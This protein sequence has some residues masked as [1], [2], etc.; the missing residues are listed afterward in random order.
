MAAREPSGSS[1]GDGVDVHASRLDDG[2]TTTI[3]SGECASSGELA[4]IDVSDGSNVRLLTY[5]WLST[6][7]RAL[8]IALERAAAASLCCQPVTLVQGSWCAESVAAMLAIWKVNAVYCPVD[9][10]WPVARVQS[11]LADARP[12]VLLCCRHVLGRLALDGLIPVVSVEDGRIVHLPKRTVS[13]EP[14][15]TLPSGTHYLLFTSGTTGRPKV[16]CGS[17]TGLASRLQWGREAFGF[18]ADEVAVAST[19]PTFI[20]SFMEVLGALDGR[21]PLVLPQARL[22]RSPQAFL[23]LVRTWRVSRLTMVPTALTML[24]ETLEPRST[25]RPSGAPPPPSASASASSLPHLRLLCSSGEALTTALVERVRRQLPAVRLINLY[26][27]SECSADVLCFECLAGSSGSSGSPGS[28]GSSGSPGSS[29]SS[30][31]LAQPPAYGRHDGR[32]DE[33]STGGLVP[34]GH[35]I[36]GARVRLLAPQSTDAAGDAAGD[37]ARDGAAEEQGFED[38]VP[39]GELGEVWVGGEVVA[40][41]YLGQPQLTA[42]HFRRSRSIRWFRTGDL[43]RREA[44]TGMVHFHGRADAQLQLRGYRVEPLEVE[45]VFTR[46]PGVLQAVVVPLR[47]PAQAA[48]FPFESALGPDEPPGSAVAGVEFG[49]PG[50]AVALMLLCTLAHEGTISGAVLGA[51]DEGCNQRSS[52]VISAHYE[53]TISGE[54]AALEGGTGFAT[55]ST[56]LSDDDRAPVDLCGLRVRPAASSRAMH[57]AFE[58]WGLAQLPSWMIPSSFVILDTLPRLG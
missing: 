17:R 57:S 19:A 30:G 51:P 24:L 14:P 23:A 32:R 52:E 11:T 43:G 48:A 34:L 31:S 28:S 25:P 3:L 44:R 6:H 46:M 54:G 5:A 39:E 45:A 55:L 40:L 58:A 2:D 42:A 8:A 49:P 15:H 33:R 38:E 56:A 53:G 21:C 37:G 41:G 36:S 13:P 4:L 35:P 22:L 26:G 50:S 18:K 10:N 1:E 27:T 16:V 29:G 9:A 20:D 47:A 7:V 12:L